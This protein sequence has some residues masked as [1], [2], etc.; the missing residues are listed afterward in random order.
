MHDWQ[1]VWR[2][3]FPAAMVRSDVKAELEFHI[4]GRVRELIA[5]GWREEDARRETLGRFGDLSRIKAD[6]LELS[7]QRIE[8]KERRMMWDDLWRD[9]R[10]AARSLARRPAFS[11]TVILTMV[12]GVG[13]TAAIFSVVNGVLLRPLPYRESGRLAIIWQN[14]RATGTVREAAS[15]ADYYDFRERSRLFQDMAMFFQRAATFSRPQG[16]PRRVNLTAAT[17]NLLDVLGVSPLIGRGV[18]QAEDRPGGEL[19]AVLAEPFWRSAFN[20]DPGAIGQRIVLDGTSFTVVGVLPAR[21]DFPAKNTD[22]WVPIQQSPASAARN[23]HF[24][25]VIGRLKPGVGVE[26]AQQEMVS[27][28]QDL[29]AEFPANRNRGAFVEPLDEVRRGAFRTSLWVLFAAVFS[30]LLIACANLANLLLA[31]WTGRTR[32]V[33]VHL[34][35]GSGVGRMARRLL[36]ENLMLAVLAAAGGLLVA[37]LGLKALLALAP[38]ALV[39]AGEV[40]VDGTVLAF[41]FL[42]SLAAG[43]GFGLVPVLQMRRLDIQSSLQ[44]GRAHG[45]SAAPSKMRIRRLMV[46]GQM[47]MAIILLAGAGLLIETL[48]NLQ[49]VDPGFQAENLLR[50]DFSLP[51]SRY[52]RN[53]RV[54]PNWPE[55]NRFNQEAVRRVEA[56]PGVVSAALTSNHPLQ[57][58]WT[59]GFAIVGRPPD[60]DKGEMTTRIVTPGYF[61][62]AG[63][64]LLAGRLMSQ[65]DRLEAP[66][67]LILNQAAAKRHFPEGDAIGQRIQLWGPTARQVIGIVEDEKMHGLGQEAPPAM[68]VNLL[69]APQR[70]A[71]TLIVRTSGDPLQSV[72]ALRQA[73]WSIDRSLALYN[74]STMDETLA[75]AVASERF[76]SV[77]LGIFACLALLLAILGVYGVL[78]HLVA[79]RSR[80]VGIRMALG[81]APAEVL[82]MVVS[83]GLAMTVAGLAVGLIGAFALT[84]A[85]AA[86]LFGVTPTEPSVFAAVA[87]VLAAASLLACL[88]PA[89]RAAGIDPMATLREE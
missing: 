54:W 29:E 84:R 8:R 76:V 61:R 33:A 78:S 25:R 51:A 16:Q 3:L 32:E 22:L 4:Q 55:V 71:L 77:I 88:V 57:S 34:A 41:G 10:L 50:L 64:A 36:I 18:S 17:H 44:E 83:Q 39:A 62:T 2:R 46:A 7:R 72:A 43:A 13:A 66:P 5:R 27:I 31:S 40:Q 12:L 14:D 23:P 6:C 47:A 15:V 52:P 85:V 86:M 59:N 53:M 82:R 20:G 24:V 49:K 58:G 37:S 9:A 45:G 1:A 19:A 65:S 30:V 35:L 38:A 74:V 79:Q 68:Y 81:A 42:L 60:P 21:L 63:V 67:V 75:Q 48:W 87:L 70:G 26:E 80:E 69:Q 73:I 11:A 28:A 89:R 56:V